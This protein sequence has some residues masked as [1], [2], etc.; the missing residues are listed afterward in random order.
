MLN[1]ALIGVHKMNQKN[2]GQLENFTLPAVGSGGSDK[3]EALRTVH[4]TRVNDVLCW[5]QYFPL[6]ELGLVRI[7]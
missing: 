7:H 4:Y 3:Y 2:D 5:C 6:S 1:I